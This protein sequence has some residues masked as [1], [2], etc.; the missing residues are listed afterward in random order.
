MLKSVAYLDYV[1]FEV[2]MCKYH[3]YTVN[4]IYHF[5]TEYEWVQNKHSTENQT[6]V[7]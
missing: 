5:I 4:Y 3:M 7:Y 6:P 2:E 1:K